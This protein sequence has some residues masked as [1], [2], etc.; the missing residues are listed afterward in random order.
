[1]RLVPEHLMAKQG[2]ATDWK[3]VL[4]LITGVFEP[5]NVSHVA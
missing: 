4:D 1:M 5:P 3:G 2:E